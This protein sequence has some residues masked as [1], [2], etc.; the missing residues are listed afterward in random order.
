[1]IIRIQQFGSFDDPN[2]EHP[3]EL[4]GCRSARLRQNG[5]YELTLANGS[6]RTVGGDYDIAEIYPDGSSRPLP[7]S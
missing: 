1:M 3:P 4:I 7:R 6:I 5:T 2:R